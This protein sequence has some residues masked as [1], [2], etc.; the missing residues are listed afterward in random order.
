VDSESLSI[1]VG[2]LI[3]VGVNSFILLSHGYCLSILHLLFC[4]RWHLVRNFLLY[5]P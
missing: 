1:N 3:L 2:I 5:D 4:C